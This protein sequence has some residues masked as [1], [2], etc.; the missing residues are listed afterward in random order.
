MRRRLFLALLLAAQG[1]SPGG[2]GPVKPDGNVLPPEIVA[3]MPAH[4][5]RSVTYD[6]PVIWATFATDLDT[7]TVTPLNIFLKRDSG[8]VPIAVR[9]E[10]A[11]RRIVIDALA[12]LELSRTYTVE[13]SP[14]LRTDQAPFPADRAI[15]QSPF[16]TLSWTG[17]ADSGPQRYDLYLSTDSAVVATRS[18]PPYDAGRRQ[19]LL[20]RT[21]WPQGLSVWWSVR[22]TDLA[23]GESVD[24]PIW[25]FDT[26]DPATAIVD[27]LVLPLNEVGNIRI[28]RVGGASG[29]NYNCSS[30]QTLTSGPD[31]YTMAV[32]WNYFTTTPATQLVGASIELRTTPAYQD[33]V[34]G[35]ES[36]WSASDAFTCRSMN[37]PGPP[38]TDEPAGPLAVAVLS[39]PRTLR[40]A[41]DALTTHVQASIQYP[42]RYFGYIFRSPRAMQYAGIF[43][44]GGAPAPRLTIYYHRTGTAQQLSSASR[45]AP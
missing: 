23:A 15:N 38:F 12:Q 37:Y 32:S 26:F 10:P 24:G 13:L 3:V 34:T 5:T 39:P 2:K 27:S 33:S 41:S 18:I 36:I 4:Q 30:P 45:R 20:P 11:S 31:I 6:H 40:Y 44:A 22:V 14:N 35:Q 19:T 9:W 16:V 1:C 28:V 17:N 42:G 25:R 43:A 21:R 7:T 8:R 29:I